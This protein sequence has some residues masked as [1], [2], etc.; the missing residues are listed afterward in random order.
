VT[1]AGSGIGRATAKRLAQEGAL[2][3]A[4]DMV[5]SR[6]DELVREAAPGDV[7]AVPGDIT[8][9]ATVAA[10]VAAANGRID[11]LANVAGIMD[12]FLPAGEVDDATWERVIAV[13]LTAV[14]RLTRAVLPLMLSQGRGSI[15]NVASEAAFRGSAAGAAYTSSK[16]AVVGLTR[17]TAFIYAPNGIRANAVAPGPVR[18]NI[19]APM[20]SPLAAARL[21]PLFQTNVPPVAEPEQLA[22]AITWLASDDAANVTG[23]VLA[24]DGGWS[25]L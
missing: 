2:V 10:L 4:T 6:L 25:A 20:K 23:I 11:V 21:G 15:V 22:A 12:G 1:G 7:T 17:S 19:D 18:T 8:S 14:F 3:I 13:N 9:E 5:Q 24:S 16:H